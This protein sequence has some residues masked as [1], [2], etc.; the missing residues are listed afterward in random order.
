M[1]Q[2]T[3]SIVIPIYNAAEYLGGCI[4]SIS[5]STHDN[6]Q[7]I[8]VDDGSDDGVTPGLCDSIAR[9]NR[10][11]E[12][13]HKRNGGSASARNCGFSHVYGEWVWFVDADDVI[14]PCAVEALS[15]VCTG[16]LLDAVHF[17]FL[18]F[19]ALRSPDWSR[20][21][22]SDELECLSSADY[23]MGLYAGK[24]G[25]Y[26][27]SFLYRTAFL[28]EHAQAANQPF[29]EGYTLYEDVVA[30][31]YLMRNA[32]RVG[33]LRAQLYG[34]RLVPTSMSNRRSNA[35]AESGLR[36]VQSLRDYHAPKGADRNKS[37]MEIGL[38]FTAYRLTEGGEASDDLRR[39]IVDEIDKRV[40]AIGIHRVGFGR[41]A[42][43][44]LLKTGL[45]DCL[46]DL[47]GRLRH[48]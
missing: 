47:R 19:E 10:G 37:R 39:R 30:T 25:H 24:Y 1:N 48:A 4:E 7:V 42:R 13:V 12:V 20:A 43:Y 18:N 38:L 27:W 44:A 28:R 26:V 46:I 36:A 5:P 17:D 32:E 6:L 9:Q 2:P 22:C 29:Q 14:A 31:E 23:L 3:I 34:Y 21:Y 15:R 11:V 35:A 40:R 16:C 8:L 33:V 45:L 41:L